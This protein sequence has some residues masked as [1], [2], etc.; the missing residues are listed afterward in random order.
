MFE[1]YILSQSGGGVFNGNTKI[2]LFLL[3]NY[4]GF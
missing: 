3:L 2:I 1:K 4:K